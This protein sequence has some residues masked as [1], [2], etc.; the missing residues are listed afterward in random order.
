MA[1]MVSGVPP[2]LIS[3]IGLGRRNIVESHQPGLLQ[4]PIDDIQREERLAT[5]WMA[6]FVD[7]SFAIHLNWAQSMNLEDI[8]CQLPAGTVEFCQATIMSNPQ[9]GHDLDLLTSHPIDDTFVLSIKSAILLTKAA[10][11]VRTWQQRVITPGDQYEGLKS[12]EFVVLEAG[13]VEF[14]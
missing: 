1:W 8:K 12:V 14:Q 6:F 10:R 9:T 7:A 4:P 5:I 11:W 13:V 2:R 3:S